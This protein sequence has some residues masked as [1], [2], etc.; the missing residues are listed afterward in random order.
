MIFMSRCIALLKDN[1]ATSIIRKLIL[2]IILNAIDGV[3]TYISLY[4]QYAVELNPISDA[5]IHEFW[6]LIIY[7]ITLPTLMI[8]VGIYGIKKS[9]ERREE[10]GIP[11][12][13]NSFK[14]ANVSTNIGLV[15]YTL[16]LLNHFIVL[17]QLVHFLLFVL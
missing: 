13:E 9:S 16:I 3:L 8:I 12:N 11:S 6:G 17:G 5:F 2:V 1:Q 10:R 14:V 7:K 4:Y 15:V